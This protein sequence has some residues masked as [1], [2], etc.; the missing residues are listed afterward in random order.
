MELVRRIPAGVRY[1]VADSLR[2]TTG[3][4]R[5]AASAEW[6]PAMASL[7]ELKVRSRYSRRRRS[8][9]CELAARVTN[10]SRLRARA[11]RP[12][13]CAR[14]SANPTRN[15]AAGSAGLRPAPADDLAM[16]TPSGMGAGRSDLR[17]RHRVR[18]SRAEGA[19]RSHERPHRRRHRPPPVDRAVRAEKTVT[20]AQGGRVVEA[21]QPR[22][23][24]RP[25]TMASTPRLQ[26]LSSGRPVSSHFPQATRR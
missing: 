15:L 1:K 17:A 10:A 2:G 25:P 21:G 5:C 8:N 11:M 26:Q 6:T 13:W 19:G 3:S 22:R 9:W 23:R 24:A 20:V 7:S 16:P 12:C 4:R 14:M 18:G